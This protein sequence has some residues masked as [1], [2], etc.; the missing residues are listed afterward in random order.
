MYNIGLIFYGGVVATLTK[1]DFISHINL[2]LISF[3]STNF[4]DP[5]LRNRYLYIYISAHIYTYKVIK[6]IIHKLHD[7]ILYSFNFTELFM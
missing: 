3:V 2:N 4:A 7:N 1:F 5:L 6:M